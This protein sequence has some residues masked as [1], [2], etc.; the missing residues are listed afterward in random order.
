M[1]N[2]Q[3]KLTSPEKFKPKPSAADLKK[4]EKLENQKVR[5]QLLATEPISDQDTKIFSGYLAA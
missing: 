3:E 5:D 1:Q 4:K 2:M